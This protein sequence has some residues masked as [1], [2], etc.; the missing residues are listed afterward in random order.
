MTFGDEISRFQKGH[1]RIDQAATSALRPEQLFP[2][3]HIV[4]VPHQPTQFNRNLIRNRIAD[5]QAEKHVAIILIEL[6][7]TG[8]QFATQSLGL[9]LVCAGADQHKLVA[10]DP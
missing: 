9:G 4:R 1:H 8:A 10:A 3:H 2:P 5:R 6:F 7:N